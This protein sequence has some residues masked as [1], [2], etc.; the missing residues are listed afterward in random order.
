MK[1]YVEINVG[2]CW[3]LHP[4]HTPTLSIILIIW[5]IGYNIIDQSVCSHID[6]VEIN[7][8]II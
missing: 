6:Y 8:L 4:Q 2:C 7:Y 3:L 1:A 5:K